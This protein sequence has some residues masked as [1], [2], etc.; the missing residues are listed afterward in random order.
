MHSESLLHS[1]PDA[2]TEESSWDPLKDPVK[3][4]MGGR[5]TLKWPLGLVSSKA[6]YCN[7]SSHSAGKA[8][9]FNP[10]LVPS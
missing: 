3:A 5:V 7:S 1:G 10:F 4:P 9:W 2:R 6:I 8:V